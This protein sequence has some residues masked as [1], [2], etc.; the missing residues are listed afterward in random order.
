MKLP[1]RGNAEAL[2]AGLKPCQG[3]V[4]T[5]EHRPVVGIRLEK[6][7]RL[8]EAEEQIGLRDRAFRE[9]IEQAKFCLSLIGRKAGG[10]GG[11]GLHQGAG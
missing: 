2:D 4:N 8:V 10:R 5:R 3:A 1:A 6:A 9:F 7:E 11:Q